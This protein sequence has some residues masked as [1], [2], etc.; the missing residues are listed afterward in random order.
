[1]ISQLPPF[2]FHLRFR[3]LLVFGIVGVL[4]TIV[5]FTIGLTLTETGIAKPFLAN[6]VAFTF[7]FF[8]SYIG[9]YFFTFQSSQDHHVAL[10][11]FLFVAL[12]GL[13][14][15]QIIV[16]VLVDRLEQ[17]YLLALFIVTTAVPVITFLFGRY[18]VFKDPD[19]GSIAKGK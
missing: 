7:A 11:R 3:K 10:R 16:I 18:W 1:M 9:H 12:V 17:P 14:L 4:A 2:K 13:S 15:N 8:V 19:V 5:H 6:F